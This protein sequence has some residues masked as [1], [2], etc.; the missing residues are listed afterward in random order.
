M[1]PGV[2]LEGAAAAGA[3]A[4]GVRQLTFA[5]WIESWHDFYLMAGTAAVTLVAK[6]H[7]FRSEE[8]AGDLAAAV[9]AIL[10][11]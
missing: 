3:V 9:D 11:E 5:E 4:E 10:E 6:H 7:T 1:L 8:T 2:L